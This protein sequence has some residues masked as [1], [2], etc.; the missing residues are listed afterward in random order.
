MTQTLHVVVATTEFAPFRGGL[1]SYSELLARGLAA[2]GVEV[3]VLAPRYRDGPNPDAIGPSPVQRF[4]LKPA[5]SFLSRRWILARALWRATR[6][7]AAGERPVVIATTYL[8]A[9]VAAL[10]TLW[11][12][13]RFR[14][15]VTVCGPELIGFGPWSPREWWR[16]GVLRLLGR[17]AH[18][19][20]CI[21]QYT[22]ALAVQAGV[23]SGRCH[24]VF[25]GVSPEAFYRDDGTSWRRRVL[26]RAEGPL[27]LT[28]GRLERRKGHDT[29]LRAVATLR[30]EFS[31]LRY[32]IIGVGPEEGRLRDLARELHLEE[33]VVWYGRADQA[34]LRQAYSAA[35][36]FFFPT[37][38]EGRNVEAQGIV[39]IEAGLCGAAVAVGR[40]GGATE[41]VEHE[42]TGLLFDPEDAAAAAAAVRR[43]LLDPALRQ[44]LGRSA[45]TEWRSRFGV[46]TMVADTIKVITSD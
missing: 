15:I 12:P 42:R 4:A 3:L 10:L 21:S 36:L 43:L 11:S 6:P 7:R 40:H 35:D 41:I 16:R 19:I 39:I 26:G 37:R 45:A 20:I 46:D 1:A 2:Q 31:G 13:R 17:R 23:P 24:V 28:V 22:K 8:F 32:V 44:T 18:G 5:G 30:Q 38:Q 14:L 34:E 33:L 29:A 9:Q 25:V 27:L